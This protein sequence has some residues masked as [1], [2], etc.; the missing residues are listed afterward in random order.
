LNDACRSDTTEE[1]NLAIKRTKKVYAVIEYT[2]KQFQKY[3]VPSKT[4]QYMNQQLGSRA[5]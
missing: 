2:A 4:L 1:S 3:F 5:K